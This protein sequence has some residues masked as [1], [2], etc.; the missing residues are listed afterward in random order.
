MSDASATSGAHDDP[1]LA[2]ARAAFL[3]LGLG[4]AWGRPLEFKLVPDVRGMVVDTTPGVFR[5]TDDTQMA[6][7]LARAI[8]DLPPGPLVE[9][10][11]GRAVGRRFSQ[12][13]EDPLTPKLAPGSTCLRGARAFARHGDWQR[14]GDRGSD[15][16]GAVMRI[17]PVALA[18]S[19]A[20]LVDAARISAIVT[21]AH[22]NAVEASIAGSWLARQAVLLGRFDEGLVARAI[23]HL[24]RD[25]AWGGSVAES[26]DAALE[27]SQDDGDWLDEESVPPGDGG[28]RSGSALGLAVA[29]VLRWGDEGFATTIE[30]ATRIEGDSDSVGALAGMLL[31]GARGPTC[32][33]AHWLDG[34]PQREELQEL[35]ARCWA[36]SAPLPRRDAIADDDL[37]AP[38]EHAADTA[39]GA[40][41][42]Q[43]ESPPPLDSTRVPK[44]AP[45]P[46]RRATPAS[47]ARSTTASPPQ[48][49]TAPAPETP[50]TAVQLSLTGAPAAP[51][52]LP[53]RPA[54]APEAPR[55]S[56]DHPLH[57][58]WL[59]LSTAGPRAPRGRIG[60]C[61][62][63]GRV[64]G[65]TWRRHLG[66]DLDRLV[67]LYQVDHMLLLLDPVAQAALGIAAIESEAEARG[68]V[69]TPL[70]LGPGGAPTVD[71]GTAACAGLLAV[72]RAGRRLAIV[73]RDGEERPGTLAAAV[74]LTLGLDPDAALQVARAAAGPRA[75][76]SADQRAFLGA[77]ATRGGA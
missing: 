48:A 51:A 42:P 60:L 39:D 41:P 2:R 68:I 58:R 36:R 43:T 45:A 7:Y 50:R 40:V 29:A 13:A 71:Q 26:L 54:S 34:L 18:F 66:V 21:H 28:W 32:L 59:D 10:L 24:G 16:C 65:G 14:S 1:T 15:G 19:G 52:I 4:D 49:R 55:T 20:E 64:D 76:T 5:W 27:L 69:V 17:L 74:L 47:T 11:F 9:D 31:A 72:A 77:F 22:P 12:W 70:P 33:P 37:D 53:A 8:L 25:W 3:G 23:A 57:V 61:P 44:P 75:A 35:A 56:L 63:P 46:E 30:K 62:A 38:T 67:S 73:G 6:M